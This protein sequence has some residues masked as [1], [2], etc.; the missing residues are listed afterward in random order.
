VAR[1]F[2]ARQWQLSVSPLAMKRSKIRR[3]TTGCGRRK[4]SW[5][6]IGQRLGLCP[7]LE[8]TEGDARY[9]FDP[10]WQV[11]RFPARDVL[12]AARVPPE[13]TVSWA[14]KP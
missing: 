5:T 6:C 1:E 14:T 10:S 2:L 8:R 12:R 9:V 7:V 4:A 13:E 3:K 11:R